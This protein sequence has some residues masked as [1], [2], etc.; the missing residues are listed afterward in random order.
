MRFEINEYIIHY[1]ETMVSKYISFST[2]PACTDTVN[3]QMVMSRISQT[4][5]AKVPC[6]FRLRAPE[7]LVP[8]THIVATKTLPAACMKRARPP[9][10]DLS[11]QPYLQISSHIQS[12]QAP[13]KPAGQKMRNINFVSKPPISHWSSKFT[14][15]LLVFQI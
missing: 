9:A 3:I 6:I 4:S 7:L 15:V 8:Y 11:L 1:D 12:I 10:Q 5:D 2:Y 13:N 14:N